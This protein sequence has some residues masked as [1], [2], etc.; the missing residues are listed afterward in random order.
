[1]IKK[2]RQKLPPSRE[3]QVVRL[4]QTGCFAEWTYE[5]RTKSSCLVVPDGDPARYPAGMYVST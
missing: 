3:P 5:G 1:M 4:R 2:S